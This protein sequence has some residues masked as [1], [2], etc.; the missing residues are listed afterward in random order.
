MRLLSLTVFNVD[1]MH[2]FMKNLFDCN[3]THN[4][5]EFCES[6]LGIPLLK[7]KKKDSL[8]TA[9]LIKK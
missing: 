3:L 9:R 6:Y 5:T 2:S 4:F 7:F 1:Q 8:L